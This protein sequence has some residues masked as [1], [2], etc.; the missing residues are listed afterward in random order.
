M[1]SPVQSFPGFYF[2]F[3]LSMHACYKDIHP[4]THH[5]RRSNLPSFCSE[6]LCLNPSHSMWLDQIYKYYG[7]LHKVHTEMQLDRLW[8][9]VYRRL[10]KDAG[11]GCFD[12]PMAG[13]L[14]RLL[15]VARNLFRCKRSCS[16]GRCQVL[17]PLPPISAEQCQNHDQMQFESPGCI[18]NAQSPHLSDTPPSMYFFCCPSNNIWQYILANF[19]ESGIYHNKKNKRL[20]LLPKENFLL[21]SPAEKAFDICPLSLET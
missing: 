10:S 8:H 2:L 17:L 7:S 4:D 20:P 3:L 12:K 5:S 13:Q 6:A 21:D 11:C 16:Y 18:K 1:K 9:K 14:K 15:Y 19:A